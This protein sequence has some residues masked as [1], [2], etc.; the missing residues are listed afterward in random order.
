M[1]I[2]S[3]RQ[4]EPVGEE[5]SE[6]LSKLALQLESMEC[7]VDGTTT[8]LE[9]VQEKVNLAMTSI[10][11]VQ[12]EQVQVVKQLKSIIGGV[13][14]VDWRQHHGD[15]AI[16]GVNNISRPTATSSTTAAPTATG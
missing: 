11:I 4:D 14:H 6:V 12:E 7:K 5:R 1:Y 13:W 16:L 15:S 9:K 10:S 8:D 3:R 2:F